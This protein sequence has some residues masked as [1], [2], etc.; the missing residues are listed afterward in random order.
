MPTRT[1]AQNACDTGKVRVN[2]AATKSAKKIGVG[3][4]IEVRNP[5]GT[6]VVR[7]TRTISKRV[8]AAI[9]AECYETV[10]RTPTHHRRPPDEPVWAVRDRGAGR[11][12]KRDR[13]QIDRLRGEG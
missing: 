11:P 8:G 13:R 2:G 6:V 3:D 4:E 5:A 1:A 7:V 12:T 9:A 10:S